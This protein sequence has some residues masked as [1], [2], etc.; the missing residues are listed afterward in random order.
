MRTKG[1]VLQQKLVACPLIIIC[2]DDQFAVLHV[3]DQRLAG[4]HVAVQDALGKKCFDRVLQIPA[5]RSCAEL[6]VIGCVN[7]E[8]L[9]RRSQLAFKLLVGKA[10][11]ERRDLQVDNAG[12]ILLRQRL[13]EHNL[14][15]PVEE[16]RAEIA[17]QKRLHLVFRILRDLALLCDTVQNGL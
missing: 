2:V 1:A 4:Q 3:A 7:D 5:Q 8:R 17:A 10:L 15:Q 13:I 11:V 6:R 16:L 14:V 9:C 12:D